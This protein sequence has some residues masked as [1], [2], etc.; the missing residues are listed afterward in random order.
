M[1][2]AS[3]ASFFADVKPQRLRPCVGTWDAVAYSGDD[4]PNL[5]RLD[6]NKKY[7]KDL[8]G[9]EH[10][11]GEIW[12]E[13]L[14]EARANL[15]RQFGE[16]EGRRRIRQLVMDGM[17]LS[18]PSLLLAVSIGALFA[19]QTQFSVILAVA[20]VQ[21]P[22]FGR[23]LR[24]T[25]LAQRASDIDWKRFEGRK[26]VLYSGT[27]EPYQG[28]PMLIESAPMVLRERP[29]ALFLLV[30]G[31]A[32]QVTSMRRAAVAL[33]VKH[34]VIFTGNLPPNAIKSFLKRADVLVS[35]RLKGTNTPM[36]IYSYLDSGTA[37]LATRLRTHTQVLDDRTAYLVDPEPLALGTGV[38]LDFQHQAV[39][40][41]DGNRRS[42]GRKGGGSHDD[43]GEAGKRGEIGHERRE[44]LAAAFDE[45]L[46]MA[47]SLSG[48]AG[49]T[50]TL[51]IRYRSPTPLYEDLRFRAWVDRV[52][53]RK[54]FTSGTCHAGE[55][56]TAEAEGIFISVDRE[57]FE[58]LLAERQS[59]GI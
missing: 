7:P 56:L 51:T 13:A 29:D 16:T 31:T 21:V 32:A 37:V 50:G 41:D 46:G 26:V 47:Q 35:P 18:V 55:R 48:Q 45:V 15:I 39:F 12:V 24:G 9:E 58:K 30:G 52:E 20:I 23:L 5:R 6:S 49:F 27:F 8:V 42:T 43:F 40:A 4:P 34:S 3:S 59:K 2:T 11:D 57:R 10:A 19:Q 1:H 54:I 44:S 33:K 36:K 53:G 17:M 14:W 25:M 38:R 28:L 22:I